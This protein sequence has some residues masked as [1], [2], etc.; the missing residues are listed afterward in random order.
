[1]QYAL[2]SW[3]IEQIINP[4]FDNQGC[5]RWTSPDGMKCSTST[6]NFV[7]G[8]FVELQQILANKKY[9]AEV[10]ASKFF[11]A[12]VSCAEENGIELTSF[13][14]HVLDAMAHDDFAEDAVNLDMVDTVKSCADSINK[15]SE[16]NGSFYDAYM[17]VMH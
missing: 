9:E 13:E 6:D 11:N 2:V 3:E 16:W 15:A 7:L 4:V 5:V 10:I 12:V 14:K 1:M 8:T 17:D